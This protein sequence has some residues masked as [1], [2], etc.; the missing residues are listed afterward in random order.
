[1][2]PEEHMTY[3][4][5]PEQTALLVIDVQEEYF[6]IEG[7]ASFPEAIERLDKLNALIDAF[8]AAGSSV[9]YVRH[10]HRPTGVDLGRMGDFADA[11][12]EDS[13]IE[14]TPRVAFHE[15]LRLLEDKIVVSKTRY[16][17]F[18]GTD[19]DAI[20]R[21]LG[22]TTVVIS[23]Y[24][25]SF[26]CDSTARSAQSRDYETVF[27]ID[28]VGGPDLEHLDGRPYPSAEVL[29]DVSAALAAGFAE[30]L[31]SAEVIERLQASGAIGSSDL[32]G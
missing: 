6:D 1:M 27:V 9:V 26:C 25:T 24:M 23:G 8:A 7:P 28:A 5:K 21:T 16:D 22:I 4:L 19:L 20:L 29:D 10:A 31:R 3:A 12:E 15:G 2:A 30:I 13:F 18:Q 17:A 11:D 32:S 14:G